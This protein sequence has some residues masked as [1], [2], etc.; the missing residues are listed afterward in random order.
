LPAEQLKAWTI[1]SSVGQ[2]T[3]FEVRSPAHR[4]VAQSLAEKFHDHW[5]AMSSTFKTAFRSV[6]EL[7]T[8][9]SQP[10]KF[11]ICID[12]QFHGKAGSVRWVNDDIVMEIHSESEAAS[13]PAKADAEGLTR[14]Q[15]LSIFELMNAASK[16]A[17]DGLRRQMDDGLFEEKALGGHELPKDV[18]KLVR[19]DADVPALLYALEVEKI[20]HGNVQ[21]CWKV[22]QELGSPTMDSEQAQAARRLAELSLDEYVA[23]QAEKGHMAKIRDRYLT[24]RQSPTA[25]AAQSL[26]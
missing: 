7:L 16:E 3:Q 9:D 20:E 5:P 1:V 26:P 22:I 19:E 21:R 11:R 23:V 12:D 6:E 15:R 4:E 2:A 17:F 13:P 10:H 18:K 14:T 8:K 25:P 24:S